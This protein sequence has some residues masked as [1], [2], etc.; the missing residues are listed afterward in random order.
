[1]SR[2]RGCRRSSTGLRIAHLSDFHLGVAVA[3]DA[4][5]SSAPSSGSRSGSP[6]SSLITR[7]PALAAAAARRSCARCSA[8]LPRCYAVL[9]NHDYAVRPRPVLAAGR[10]RRPRSRRRCCS[11]DAANGRAARPTGADRRRRP[12]LVPAR[13]ARGRSGSPIPTPTCASCSATSRSVIDRIPEGAF[14][15]VLVGPPARRARSACRT[16]AGGCGSRTSAGAVHRR[17]STAG[18]RRRCT[19]RAGLGTTFVPFRF[20]ARPEATELLLQSALMEG[21]ASVATDVLA[22]YAADAAR[23]VEGVARAR[24]GTPPAAAAPCV[25]AARTAWPSS[26]TSRSTWGA[27][28]AGRSGERCSSGSPS[29]SSAWP[30]PRPRTVDVVVDEIGAVRVWWP[31]RVAGLTGATLE[32]APSVCHELRVVAVACGGREP[33]KRRWIEQGGGRS[34]APGGRSTTTTTGGCSARCSTARSALFPRAASCRPAR[35]RDD[36][37]L[38]TCAYLVDRSTPVGDAVALPGRDRRGEGPGR[39]GARGVRLPLPGGRVGRTSASS[40][41][42]RSSRAT[43]WPTSASRPCARRAAVEL[44]RLELGGLVPVLEGKRAKVLRVLREALLPDP[45]PVPVPRRP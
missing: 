1:M 33:D 35:P 31:P 7:R 40:S 42:A 37:V 26:C 19:S 4:R 10:R 24:R 36:A 41:T 28:V 43:S 5:R 22:R 3:R 34:G 14:D 27:P 8:R 39:G 25:S 12:A 21:N 38:V 30:T 32:T 29:T 20:F 9:G 45:E 11:D 16:R 2:C 23:E 15:L 6:T 17:A 18:R 44:A 13:D